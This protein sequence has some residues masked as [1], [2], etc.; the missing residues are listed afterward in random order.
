M[1]KDFVLENLKYNNFIRKYKNSYGIAAESRR[2]IR[3]CQENSKYMN[4]ML[5]CKEIISI[6]MQID[7]SK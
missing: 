5:G 1:N 3:F 2:C 7:I 4:F 6:Y